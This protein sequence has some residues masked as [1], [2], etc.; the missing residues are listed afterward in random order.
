[1]AITV[2]KASGKP[3][4]FNLRKLV[5][6]LIRAGAPREVALDI[7]R[8][9]EVQVQ[10]SSHTRHIFRLAKKML[11]QYNTASGMRYS[12]KKALSVLG[13]SGYPFEK[14]FARILSVYGY[15]V[16]LNKIIEGFCVRHEVDI[17]ASKDKEHFVVECKYHSDGGKPTDVKTAL[18]VHSRYADIK[19][20]Y[21]MKKD[22]TVIKQ[23]WLVTNT[24]C[25]LD[26]LRY[27]ECA[28]LRI[29]SWRYPGG[30]G[31]ETMIEQKRL[32]P[33][34]ILSSVKKYSLDMLFA[35]DIILAQDISD[36]DE[37]TFIKE[38]GLDNV[39]ARAL[40]KEADKICPCM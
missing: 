23:G 24:R 19:K 15:S 4:E 39:T 38:S 25:T 10:P 12:I 28:G 21:E 36:M 11:R 32:Y 37:E 7:A 14:Y 18:Y 20:A 1:M 22:D 2:I 6:S 17:M 33:V 35:N 34:T 9:V 27:A 40:K 29:I 31:L 16:E 3:E 8:K 5:E 30:Q 26:A 13:P